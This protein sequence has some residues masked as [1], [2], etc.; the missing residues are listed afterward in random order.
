MRNRERVKDALSK[1]TPDDGI[2]I[3]YIANGPLYWYDARFDCADLWMGHTGSAEIFRRFYGPGGGFGKVDPMVEFPKVRCPV[4]IASGV[5]DFAAAAAPTAWHK[6]KDLLANHSYRVFEKSGHFPH[7]EE[8]A[9]FDS[10]LL[11]WLKR[12]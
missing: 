11:G 2:I 12:N 5:F 4:L 6:A 7:F 1:A 8:Q 10:T 3:N 9:L